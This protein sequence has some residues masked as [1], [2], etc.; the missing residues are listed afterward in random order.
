[1]MFNE[2]SKHTLETY[3]HVGKSLTQALPG[4][5]QDQ[6]PNADSYFEADE[7]SEANEVS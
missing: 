2:Y 7:V 4:V 3:L 6:F 5:Q 1:M